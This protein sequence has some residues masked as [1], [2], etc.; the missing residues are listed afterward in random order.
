M[1]VLVFDLNSGTKPYRPSSKPSRAEDVSCL[2]W[3][4]VADYILAVGSNSGATG[5]YDLRGKREIM[6]LAY[7]GGRRKVT[8]I[9]W[10]PSTVIF[11][12]NFLADS[13]S[14]S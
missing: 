12:Y 6:K 1:K 9:S 4:Q 7:P 11:S 13:F 2:S 5:V 3:N 14:D 10:H 8:G